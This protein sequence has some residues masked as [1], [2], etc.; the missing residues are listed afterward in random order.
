MYIYTKT[1]VITLS[2][3]LAR[4]AGVNVHICICIYICIYVHTHTHTCI[5]IYN[6][7]YIH[8]HTYTHSLT[9][10]RVPIIQR[11]RTHSMCGKRRKP[12]RST[13]MRSSNT[14]S[15]RCITFVCLCIFCMLYTYHCTK[16]WYINM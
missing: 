8:K 1:S 9:H 12:R 7:I 16:Q 6:N 5:Y 3:V 13:T 15:T 2:Q 4:G 14:C 10:T 11:K